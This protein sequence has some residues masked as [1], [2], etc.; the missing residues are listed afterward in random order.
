VIR[1]RL[2]PQSIE[3]IPC[4]VAIAAFAEEALP[5]NGPAGRMDSHLDGEAGRLIAGGYLTGASGSQ[6]LLA[7]EGRVA[8]DFVLFAG[9][10]QMTNLAAR[11]MSFRMEKVV[12][13]A[14]KLFARSVSIYVPPESPRS[15]Y[16]NFAAETLNGALRG[17]ADYT[18]DV[19]L[20]FSEP[21]SGRYKELTAAAERI[22]F[23]R[24]PGRGVSVEVIV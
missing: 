4:Y 14:A 22:V 17:A 24:V 3:N 1:L 13:S 21:D 6:A 18:Y 19:D 5:L 20:I 7:S 16:Q 23:R 8:A 15:E 12:Q 2:D 10:G 11:E 9:M